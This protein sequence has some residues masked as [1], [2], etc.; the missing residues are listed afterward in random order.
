MMLPHW[1]HHHQEPYS[2]SV[3]LPVNPVCQ[4]PALLVSPTR[5]ASP[6]QRA[7]FSSLAPPG[8]LGLGPG[9]RPGRSLSAV[10]PT[11]R[12]GGDATSA[13]RFAFTNRLGGRFFVNNTLTSATLHA[14]RETRAAAQ[15]RKR[16]EAISASLQNEIAEVEMLEKRLRLLHKRQREARF[17]QENAA[18]L[19]IQ[20]R[21][22]LFCILHHRA[23][24]RKKKLA[25]SLRKMF[26]G[27][28]GKRYAA[29]AR[30]RLNAE[31]LSAVL[32]GSIS[33]LDP[34]AY[35]RYR[36]ESFAKDVQRWWRDRLRCFRAK[37]LQ[38]MTA[39]MM[40]QSTWRG[41]VGRRRALKLAEI[42]ARKQLLGLGLTA[43]GRT[44]YK[45]R[46]TC[47]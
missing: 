16:F 25:G 40:I 30:D 29:A 32:S 36:K 3:H 39:V 46:M 8:G 9:R 43:M 26:R 2:K 27:K 28:G 21:W 7:A 19:M 34:D 13:G 12:N 44:M 41:I 4:N 1:M 31:L 24:R 23:R 5:P 42:R 15:A 47:A 17:R 35:A 33:G 22:R 10:S 45:K 38:Y 18:A 6:R 14:D 37:E 20:R 11:N